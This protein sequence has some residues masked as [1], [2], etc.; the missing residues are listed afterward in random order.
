MK[1]G[2]L[3][4]WSVVLAL[5]GLLTTRWAMAAD[6]VWH[7]SRAVH[8]GSGRDIRTDEDHFYLAST[9]VSRDVITISLMDLIDVY[10]SKPIMINGQRLSACFMPGDTKVS[11]Q[12]LRT[13]G[14][15]ASTLQLQARK[16]AIVQSPLHI[17][18]DE[19]EMQVC[20][21]RY[22]PAVGYLSRAISTPQVAP[23]F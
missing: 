12:A 19:D 11:T 15:N 9:G 20:I 4:K 18:N 13:L 2:A 6:P 16:S 23:C 1:T 3:L 21:N 14:L 5:M 7:C 8:M 10:N 22:A 17:V